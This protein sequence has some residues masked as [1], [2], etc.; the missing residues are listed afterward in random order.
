MF[1]VYFLQVLGFR[2]RPLAVAHVPA[3]YKENSVRAWVAEHYGH[4]DSGMSDPATSIYENTSGAGVVG[5]GSDVYQNCAELRTHPHVHASHS[6]SPSHPH[7]SQT[8][9]ARMS[10][11]SSASA[12][13]SRTLPSSSASA[14]SGKR[15]PPPPPKRSDTTHLSTRIH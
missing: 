13:S 15:L 8:L 12:S 9:S 4:S 6:S 10:T 7:Q 1:F 3:A 2:D 11:V 5:G 14:T